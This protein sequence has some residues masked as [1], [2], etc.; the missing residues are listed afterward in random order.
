MEKIEQYLDLPKLNGTIVARNEDNLDFLKTLLSEETNH[1]EKIKF[2]WYLNLKDP[3][4]NRRYCPAYVE[5]DPEEVQLLQNNLKKAL[6]KL[7]ILENIKIDG[8]YT[9]NLD[10]IKNLRLEVKS[11][12]NTAWLEFILY[13]STQNKF[14]TKLVATEVRLIHQKLQ[15]VPD[16]GE[17]LVRHLEKIQSL[18]E[19]RI[20]HS[21]TTP[22]LE[23]EN[24]ARRLEVLV[25][26]NKKT[27]LQNT[28]RADTEKVTP[29]FWS[30][31]R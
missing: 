22:A 14:V 15:T 30:K 8:F 24:P 2:E 21:G 26:K 27:I 20:P 12:G 23:G 11:D 7:L 29:S 28:P 31:L 1:E 18:S 6:H 13:S 16:L 10:G 9:F 17:N 25:K 3:G 5:L 4:P 19:N